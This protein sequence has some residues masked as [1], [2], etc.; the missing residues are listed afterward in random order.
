MAF[1]KNI[2]ELAKENEKFR[3]VVN[4]G[5]F[6][7]VVLMVLQHGEDIGEEVHDTVDQVL[8][9]VEGT[10]ESVIEGESSPIN[11]G[12]LV[13]VDAGVKHNFKNTGDAPLKLY[14]VYSPPNHPEDRAQATK[15]EAMKEEY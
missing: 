8:V 5:K 1:H 13:Y 14:T 15:E 4:T 7:Q 2:V 6:M 3:E 11:A 9:F 12:D 10:G